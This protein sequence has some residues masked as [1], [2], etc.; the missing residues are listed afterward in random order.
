MDLYS[1]G[2]CKESD[3]TEYLSLSFTKFIYLFIFSF[4]KFKFM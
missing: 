1:P 4:T 3:M 2:V